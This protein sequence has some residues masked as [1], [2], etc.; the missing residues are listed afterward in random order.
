MSIEA[1]KQIYDNVHG[2]IGVT[3]L[4]LKVIDSPVFQRLRNIMMLG[5]V[6]LVYPGATNTRFEH[7]LG[8]MFMMDSFLSHVRVNGAVLADDRDTVQKLRLA[9]LL[10]DIGHYPLSHTME[11]CIIRKM[12]GKSHESLGAD[13]IKK[14]FGDLLDNY[15]AKEISEIILGRADGDEGMLLSSAFDA[16][17][18]DYL[19]RDAHN[20]GVGYGNVGIQRL[21]RIASFEKGRIIFDKDEAAVESFLLG[22]YHMFRSVYHHKTG[23]AFGMMA[24]RIFERLVDE[25]EITSPIELAGRMDEDELFA[26]DDHM[27]FSAMRRYMKAGTDKLTKE[28]I[29]MFLLRK[30]LSASYINPV[31]DEGEDTSSN[32]AMIRRMEYDEKAARE[33]ADAAGIDD[34]GWIFPVY[35]RPLGL[36]DDKSS[37][38]IRDKGSVSSIL[39]DSN[40]LIMRM[41]GKKKLYDARIYSHRRY[42]GKIQS[43]LKVGESYT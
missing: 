10:H 17:K 7:S 3:E 24:Q 27:F 25:G 5:T 35:L 34:P 23:V 18:S 4:E 6:N 16:D 12:G 15:G 26:Y 9:A 2:Y 41:I 39:K 22:R 33:F 20:T 19:L 40:G 1:R 13:I 29:G 32:N 37:I 8:T 21:L 42:K 36:V 14:F 38:Y 30:P 28:L 31:T 43:M 11:Q